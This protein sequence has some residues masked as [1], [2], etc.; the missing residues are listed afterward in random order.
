[1]VFHFGTSV[2]RRRTCRCT[3]RID[4][5]RRVDV[6]AARDVLLEDVVLDGAAEG[7]ARHAALVGHRD[8]EREQ[9][10]RRRVDGHRRRDLAER[11]PV[12]EDAHVLDR[13]D[14]HA[15]AAD[16]AARQRVVGVAAHLRRQVERDRQSGLAR[17]RAGTC[18]AG[19]TRPRCR[20]RRTGAWSRSGRGTWSAARR[21]C[22][23]DCAR[24]PEVA[25]DARTRSWPASL[26]CRRR[27]AAMPAS[28][29]KRSLRSVS[30][31]A[32][33]RASGVISGT[34]PCTISGRLRALPGS[35]RR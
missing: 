13:V 2:G 35:R 17:A 29:W 11:Q 8:V 30:L 6:G 32:L 25:L 26:A 16:L 12:Q 23:A 20:S 22:T 21:A 18:S 3:R 9:R 14:R 33:H 31:V 4:G 1:M 34:S 28:V 10:R 15:D 27:R 7:A 5:A 19:S 24:A